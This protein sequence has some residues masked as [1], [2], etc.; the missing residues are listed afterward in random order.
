MVVV[1]KYR[2]IYDKEINVVGIARQIGEIFAAEHTQELKN[3]ILTKY[4]EEVKENG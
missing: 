1:K 4:I 2:N 3:L